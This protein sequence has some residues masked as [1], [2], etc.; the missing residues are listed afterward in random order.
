MLCGKAIIGDNMKALKK[1]KIM[2]ALSGLSIGFVNGLLALIYR[3][4]KICL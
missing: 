3:H 2:T 1:E 4:S